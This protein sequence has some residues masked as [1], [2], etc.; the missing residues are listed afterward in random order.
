MT[1]KKL[2]SIVISAMLIFFLLASTLNYNAALSSI[3][4]DFNDVSNN[5][6][7]PYY[8]RMEF[9]STENYDKN[10]EYLG[11]SVGEV[12]LNELTWR[13]TSTDYPYAIAMMDK[14]GNLTFAAQD[15]FY[16]YEEAGDLL[17]RVFVRLDEYV[18]DEFISEFNEFKKLSDKYHNIGV[19]DLSVYKSGNTYI[20]VSATF[21][22]WGTDYERS[23]TF[24]DYPV[25]HVLGEKWTVYHSFNHIE[26]P[27]YDRKYY[28]LL[29]EDIWEEYQRDTADENCWN[30]GGA[31]I[32]SEESEG[33]N[34]Y[35]FFG[36]EFKI[37]YAMK[38]NQFLA[39]LF[40]DEFIYLTSYLA[41]MFSIAGGV[42]LVL[43]LRLFKK[44]QRLNDA[45]KT[46]ISAASHELKTP[47]AV[48]QNQCEC[49]ME[50]IAPE[51]NDEYVRSI[52]EE[53]LRMN[54]IVQ[55]LLSYNR[56]SQL[57]SVKK[58][59]CNLSDLV[60]RETEKY[61][62]FAESKGAEIK[63]D[64][65]K[66]ILITCNTEM[67]EMAV[68]NLISNAVRHSASP[69]TV[70]VRLKKER[71][72]PVLSISNPAF[73]EDVE[74]VESSAEILSKGDRSRQRD[75]DSI[76]LGLSVCRKIFELH[77][78]VL[79]SDYRNGKLIL[80]LRFSVK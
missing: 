20:P 64:I 51:K 22:I 52:Y 62:A 46:F 45:R 13:C 55:N 58:E 33:N 36:E 47:V 29:K 39:V 28:D 53:S 72:Y 19:K 44:S 73:T 25:T 59:E 40:S 61:L 80:K 56:I 11:M 15:Y 32:S 2:I 71:E 7:S 23:F 57:T 68:D 75:G 3:A 60:S 54:T 8:F 18:T 12:F 63:S 70:T 27:S 6:Y 14:Q 41:V 78:Y 66:D 34:V 74:I 21:I 31:F 76:G 4:E 10:A 16:T 43:C 42:F 9:E 38:Y 67:L 69:K 79:D 48:I 77:G 65:E 49:I 26:S 35:E 37:Y 30:G 50:N 24:S 5:L 17:V 1:K